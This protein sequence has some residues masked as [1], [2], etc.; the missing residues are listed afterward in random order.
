LPTSR[1]KGFGIPC[2]PLAAGGFSG[3]DV[4]GAWCRKYTTFGT[5]SSVI[6]P[7]TGEA[8]GE[9]SYSDEKL[10]ASAPA[11]AEH[12]PKRALLCPGDRELPIG[13]DPDPLLGVGAP[14]GLPQR[15]PR[16]GALIPLGLVEAVLPH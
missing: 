15:L 7:P 16:L 4:V 9:F 3:T 13:L 12:L 11:G 10:T 2:H 1:Y 14:V 6:T 5:A 8:K